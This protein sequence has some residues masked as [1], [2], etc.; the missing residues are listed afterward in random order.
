MDALHPFWSS[1]EVLRAAAE[2]R[3][4][5]LARAV[6]E[7]R[8]WTLA[9]VAAQCHLSV[10]TLSRME[11]GQRKLLDVHYL[12]TLSQVLEIPPH[13]FGLVPTVSGAA[14]TREGAWPVTVGAATSGGQD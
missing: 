12:R 2:G 7:A 13:L 3:Y 4:G 11:T 9:Q 6:R 10:S 14:E 8:H 1:P 5:A